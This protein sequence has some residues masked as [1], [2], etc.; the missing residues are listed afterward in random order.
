MDPITPWAGALPSR[1]R[2]TTSAGILAMPETW[3]PGSRADGMRRHGCGTT[4]ES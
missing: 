2:C 4:K 3:P 1:G